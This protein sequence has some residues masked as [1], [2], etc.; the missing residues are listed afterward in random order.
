MIQLKDIHSVFFLGIGGIGMSGLARYFSQKGIKVSGYDKTPSALTDDLMAEGMHICFD[1][2]LKHIPDDIDLVVY[3]PAVPNDQKQFV[4]LRTTQIPI[5]KRAQILGLIAQDK[6]AIA[7]AGTHGKTTTSSM[8]AHV[9]KNSGEDISAF[10][11]GILA[12]FGTNYLIGDS[13]WIVLEADEYD[14]SFHQLYPQ[15]AVVNAMDADHLDIY[16]TQEEFTAAF[17]QFLCQSKDDAI[18]LLKEGVSEKF[19]EEQLA[20]LYDKYQ[21]STFGFGNGCDWKIVPIQ[22]VGN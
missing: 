15:I 8:T 12:E 5:Y 19:T 11:G 6:K 18:L 14:R 4:H 16:G 13:E 22:S 7:I 10:L 21:V 17:Y 3:T 1:E 2:D 9:L 20:V